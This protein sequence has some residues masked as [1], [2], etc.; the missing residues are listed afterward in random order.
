[1]NVCYDQY[2]CL[3]CFTYYLVS[4]VTSV[5]LCFA[6]VWGSAWCVSC[7]VALGKILLGEA[8]ISCLVLWKTLSTP[9]AVTLARL[10][11]VDLHC[12]LL[13]TLQASSDR[14]EGFGLQASS[15]RW[16]GFG[17]LK[18]SELWTSKPP[19]AYWPVPFLP[20]SSYKKQLPYEWNYLLWASYERMYVAT[21]LDL[22]LVWFNTALALASNKI[23]LCWNELTSGVKHF[24]ICFPERKKKEQT[25]YIYK[26]WQT[27]K[28]THESPQLV[29][30]KTKHI[31]LNQQSLQ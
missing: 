13:A 27:K 9:T 20:E 28:V 15:D 21:V 7:S 10:A 5:N 31:I 26:E 14:W 19:V 25:S 29:E 4:F 6:V 18:V 24:H 30:E 17:K 2:W 22:G 23:K 11:V 16:E 3:C 1:M 8:F 12:V